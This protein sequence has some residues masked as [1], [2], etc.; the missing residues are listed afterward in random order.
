MISPLILSFFSPN[1]EPDVVLEQP[2]IPDA[3]LFAHN[4]AWVPVSEFTHP[5]PTA[6]SQ[7]A[8]MSVLAALDGS[9]IWPIFWMHIFTAPASVAVAA[10]A[11]KNK[12]DFFISDSPFWFIASRPLENR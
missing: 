11:I 6:H 4:V 10:A 2:D 1:T 8:A 12:I 3:Y 5:S 7:L 9:V